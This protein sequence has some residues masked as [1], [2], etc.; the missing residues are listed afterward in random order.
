MATYSGK[1]YDVII[2]NP[3]YIAFDEDI[4][5]IVYNNEPHLALFADNNGLYFYE[6]ILKN[7]KNITND[8]YLVCFE[9]GYTQAKDITDMINHYLGDVNISVVKDY[10]NRDRFIFITNI[11][12]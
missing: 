12:Q 11:E 4:D 6:K 7:I 9:I 3:P 5:D 2:S 10:A 8:K 1:K